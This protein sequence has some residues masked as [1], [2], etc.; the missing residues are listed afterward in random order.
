M[1]K[2]T[3]AYFEAR[4]RIEPI[5]VLLEEMAIPYEDQRIS[6]EAWAQMKSNTP[7]GE[8]HFTRGQGLYRR[9]KFIK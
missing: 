7:F 1:S 5:R 3:I 4:A 9:E 8:L 2:T 6:F